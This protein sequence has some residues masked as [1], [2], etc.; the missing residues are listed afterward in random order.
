[1]ATESTIQ[2]IRRFL[3]QENLWISEGKEDL[4]DLASQLNFINALIKKYEGKRD[5][6]AIVRE[7]IRRLT[8]V[9]QQA[10]VLFNYVMR[11]VDD[12]QK[13]RNNSEVVLP[14]WNCISIAGDVAGKAQQLKKT[15]KNILDD[16]QQ[17]GISMNVVESTT[18][19][20]SSNYTF[21]IANPVVRSIR[22]KEPS[23]LKFEIESFEALVNSVARMRSADRIESRV[24]FW[25]PFMG[26]GYL[27]KWKHER[28]RDQSCFSLF[29]IG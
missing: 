25:G 3:E 2:D 4:D 18:G 14:G 28:Q 9:A 11:T 16:S 17:Y 20:K 7:M 5:K 10:E 23:D 29:E 15:I 27:S 19:E 24:H 8:S 22:D 26:D 12:S 1:M 13:W 6:D 21:E